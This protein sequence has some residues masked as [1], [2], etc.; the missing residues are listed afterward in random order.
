MKMLVHPE[1]T[2]PSVRSQE[3]DVEEGFGITD[4]SSPEHEE[5]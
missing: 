2:S 3:G 5:G 4:A 1:P